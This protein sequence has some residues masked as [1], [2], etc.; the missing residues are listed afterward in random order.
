MAFDG[1][2]EDKI[3]ESPIGPH[4]CT[5]TLEAWLA[6]VEEGKLWLMNF[7]CLPLRESSVM[8]IRNKKIVP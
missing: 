5:L 3:K 7:T 2:Q 4:I 8:E 6:A 1:L